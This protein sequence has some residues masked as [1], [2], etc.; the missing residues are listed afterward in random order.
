MWEYYNGTVWANASGLSGVVDETNDS[1]VINAVPSRYNNYRFRLNVSGKCPAAVPSVEVDLTVNEKPQIDIHPQD[2]TSCEQD[3]VFFFVDAGVTTNVYLTI[4]DK[5]G[6][7]H[8]G[9]LF[10]N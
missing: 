7:E 4:V 9:T 6:V 8:E 5:S 3:T 10:V 2:E 1:L